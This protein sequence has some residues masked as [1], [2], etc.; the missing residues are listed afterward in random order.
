[1]NNKGTNLT[2]MLI[3]IVG[4]VAVTMLAFNAYNGFL[5][6]NSQSMDPVLREAYKNITSSKQLLT[7]DVN[8]FELSTKSALN[9]LKNI[10]ENIFATLAIGG[11]ILLSFFG[12]ATY[13][14][15]F[16]TIISDTIHFPE[17]LMWFLMTA[18][19]IYVAS[20]ILKAFRGTPDTA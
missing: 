20:L 2:F 19:G 9:S 13:I 7:S 8:N 1:M 4:F 15:G 17:P 16:I 18:I 12:I 10:P 3:A 6:Y 11:N 14:R 5:D